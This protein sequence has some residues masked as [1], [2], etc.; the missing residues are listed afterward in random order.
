MTDD[1]DSL[2]TEVCQDFAEELAAVSRTP[3]EIGIAL[4]RH[5]GQLVPRE[6][7]QLHGGMFE[8][9]LAFIAGAASALRSPQTAAA[10]VGLATDAGEHSTAGGLVKLVLALTDIARKSM[11]DDTLT[12]DTLTTMTGERDN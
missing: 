12:G 7:P 3:G 10:L 4:T 9:R 6:E 2:V 11:G 5:V 8:L 1:L